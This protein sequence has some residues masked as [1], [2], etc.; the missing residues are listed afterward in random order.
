MSQWPKIILWAALLFVIC[1]LLWV[2]S[3]SANDQYDA[4]SDYA[5][6]LKDPDANTVTGF[7]PGDVLPDY[8]ATPS[9]SGYYGGVT[10]TSTNLDDAGNKALAE[11][12]A[13]KAITDSIL[14]NPKDT[15]SAD[16]PF[17]SAGTDAESKAESV[18]DGS[19]EGCHTETVNKTEYSSHVCERDINVTQTCTR[20]A[21]ISGNYVPTQ[22][23][24]TV[25]LTNANFTFVKDGDYVR[26]DFAVPETGTVLSGEFDFV[27]NIATHGFTQPTT[28]NV[29][30]GQVTVP[31]YG[32]G[33]YPVS[34]SGITLTAGQTGSVTFYAN[35]S[36]HHDTFTNAILNSLQSGSATFTLRLVMM[37]QGQQWQG[38]VDWPGDCALAQ[39][40]GAVKIS[41][42][43][44]VPGGDRPVVVD[45]VTYTVHS[46]CWQYTDTYRTQDADEGS[47]A[48]YAADSAC[49]VATQQC[50]YAVDGICLHQNVT[51]SCEKK[52]SGEAQVCGGEIF[53]SDGSCAEAANGK[54]QSFQEAVSQLAAVAAAGADVAKLNDVNVK[55]FTGQPQSCRKAMAGFSNCCKGSGWGS[56]VGLA[57]CSSDEKA[58]GEAKEKLLT[59]DVGEY[60]AQKVLGVCLEKKRSY[61]VFDSKL[62]QI[63]QQQGRQWQLGVGF[64]SPESPDCSGITVPQLQALDFSKMDFKNFYADLED[65]SAVPDSDALQ[66]RIKDQVASQMQQAGGSK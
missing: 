48:E 23:Q 19:F 30:G 37:V 34:V 63:V 49:T 45:G 15:L 14:N 58:L 7:K 24:K 31:K 41:S 16:A 35:Q 10:A 4:G 18:T 60:C 5:R 3:V 26:A 44:T 12:D 36:Q 42:E 53:C 64:G 21:S 39:E 2:A 20:D 32:N 55:A 38:Q 50:A 6:T 46:D 43:C 56:D 28:V 54:S 61:C 22:E 51:Y 25:T 9:E 1:S 27:L 11:S 57:S 47:C 66:Q 59:V 8:T 33:T 65:G 40:A 62:A 13:G 52:V 17:I 29:L